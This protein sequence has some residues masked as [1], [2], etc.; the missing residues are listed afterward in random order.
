MMKKLWKDEAGS[1]VLEYI[2]IATLVS[3]ASIV[4]L[5]AVGVALNVELTELAGA[6]GNINQSYS[7]SG[8]SACTGAVSGAAVTDSATTLTAGVTPAFA[9]GGSA[10]SITVSNCP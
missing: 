10:T 5:N 4:G 1:L 3:L 8:F 6:I 2:L 9:A 7:Y